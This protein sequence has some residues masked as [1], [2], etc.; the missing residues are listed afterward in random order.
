M[1]EI[2]ENNK[3]MDDLPNTMELNREHEMN[4]SEAGTED[5]ELQEILERENLD[6]ENFLE[7]R[8]TKGDDSLPKAE[9]DKVQ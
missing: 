3:Q 2:L 9:F 4:S 7:Q 8:I 1:E 6:L 5:H